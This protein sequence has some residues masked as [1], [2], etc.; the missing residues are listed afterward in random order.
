MGTF[1]A[2]AVLG[3]LAAFFRHI[4]VGFF[5]ALAGMIV[6]AI[7]GLFGVLLMEVFLAAFERTEELRHQTRLL[8]EIKQRLDSRSD[9]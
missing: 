8:K 7:P 5:Y 4:D 6:W 1:W 2:V 3:A 9:R